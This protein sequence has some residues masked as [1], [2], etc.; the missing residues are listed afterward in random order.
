MCSFCGNEKKKYFFLW[1]IK[2]SIELFNFWFSN[3]LLALDNLKEIT[4]VWDWNN[5]RNP[6]K[7]AF[8]AN[9][10]RLKTPEFASKHNFST[11]IFLRKKIPFFNPSIIET[12]NSSSLHFTYTHCLTTSLWSNC[13]QLKNKRKKEE[14]IL[15]LVENP[16]PIVAHKARPVLMFDVVQLCTN[17]PIVQRRARAAAADRYPGHNYLRFKTDRSV[18]WITGH[19]SANTVFEEFLFDCFLAG[20]RLKV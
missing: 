17:F 20:G 12:Q 14:K 2:R 11:F 9:I 19:S 1:I 5:H 13:T 10:I 16:V 15:F 4:S 7:P 3:K 8:K 18:W 6:R